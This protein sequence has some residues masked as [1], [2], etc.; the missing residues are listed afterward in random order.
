MPFH[1]IELI[2]KCEREALKRIDEVKIEAETAL[3]EAEDRGR[4]IIKSEIERAREECRQISAASL[5]KTALRRADIIKSAEI[6]AEKLRNKS[7][8]EREHAVSYIVNT[9]TGELHADTGTNE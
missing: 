1:E 2:K 4:E 9:V 5:E 3:R 6:R 7:A 8:A